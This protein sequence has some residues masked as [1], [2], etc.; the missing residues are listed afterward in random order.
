MPFTL[1]HI[2]DLHFHA[3]PR[4]WQQWA[5]KRALG[6]ANLFF[7][8]HRQFP[9]QRAHQLVQTLQTLE[10]DHLVVSG[11]VTN[12]ALEQEFQIASAILHPLLNP[13][14]KVTIVPG[15]HDRYV[16]ETHSDDLFQ[17]YFG[18]FFSDACGRTPALKTQHLTEDWHLMG[19]DSTH[20]NDWFTASGTVTQETL[21]ASEAYMR[22][23][24]P[25]SR[26]IVVNH[27]PLWFPPHLPPHAAHE[28]HN[29]SYVLH[30]LTQHPQIVIYLHGH[31]HR[32][33]FHQI[34]RP[35]GPLYF[36]NS[37]AST[38]VALAGQQSAFHCI[39]L[40]GT[41]VTIEPV[42]F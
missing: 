36:V 17:K 32:N 9:L 4:Y 26:F 13:P 27:Y 20:P 10:W 41:Q 34:V 19:W 8:R 2:S 5:S 1:A 42:Q 24:P 6:A 7:R 15:N 29:R 23:Q 33:W 28:L 11:D 14:H 18:S 39:H 38:D 16:Q 12:L 40:A 35:C 3:L 31:I 25:R 37:A 22:A 21:L 30:W